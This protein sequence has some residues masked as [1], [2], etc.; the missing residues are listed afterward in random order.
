MTTSLHNAVKNGLLDEARN[1]IASGADVNEKDSLGRT[2]LHIAGWIGNVEITQLLLRS[3]ANI[4]AVAK[5][6]FTALIFAVQSGHID[7][8][9]VLS[10]K[11]KALLSARTT[12]GHKTCLHFAAQKNNTEMVR[13][14]IELGADVAALTNRRESAFDLTSSEE[15]REVLTEA[16]RAKVQVTAKGRSQDADGGEKRGDNQEEVEVRVGE[17]RT[18]RDVSAITESKDEGENEGEGEDED[19][20]EGGAS[21]TSD[22]AGP[23]AVK[24]KQ[25]KLDGDTD[26]DNHIAGASV[27]RPR[28]SSVALQHLVQDEE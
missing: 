15:T 7:V 14:L 9:D 12:K 4:N 11:C 20:G 28:Q 27:A 23:S 5:D 13:K 2:P 3:R 1:L 16:L 10:R 22:R 17:K 21:G 8:C 19:E 26:N 18:R 25:S 24:K 6:G